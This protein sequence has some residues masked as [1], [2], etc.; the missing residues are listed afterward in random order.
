MLSLIP[1][2]DIPN[3]ANAQTKRKKAQSIV[4]SI[5]MVTDPEVRKIWIK[6][7]EE[8]NPEQKGMLL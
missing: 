2:H 1:D 5:Q 6:D 3:D 7:L 4:K 8:K